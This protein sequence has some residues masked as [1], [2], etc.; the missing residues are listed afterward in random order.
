VRAWNENEPRSRFYDDAQTIAAGLRVPKPLGDFL[1]LDAVRQS[2][3]TAI[4]V[5]DEEMIDAGVELAE[6]EGIYA[7]PE[8]AACVAACR[9]LLACGFLRADDRVVLYNTGTGLKYPEAYSER[10]PR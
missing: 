3:G 2:G 4:A 1:V 5:T 10:F 7:A 6:D 9:K 8:G